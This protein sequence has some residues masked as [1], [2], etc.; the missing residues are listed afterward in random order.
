MVNYRSKRVAQRAFKLSG[1]CCIVCGYNL[2]ME[3][4]SRLTETAH[5]Q[6][7]SEGGIDCDVEENIIALCPQ[8][9][10]EFDSCLFYIDPETR[11]LKFKDT[12]S[13]YHNCKP[14][15]RIYHVSKYYLHKRKFYYE[16]GVRI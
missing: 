3:N 9:H 11:L 6:P 12:S 2:Q 5:L 14:V 13:V 1:E 10:K 7:F 15:G 16:R 8:H 4:G